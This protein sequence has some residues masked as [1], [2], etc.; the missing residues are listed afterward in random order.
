MNQ[1]LPMVGNIEG[2]MEGRDARCVTRD[3]NLNFVAVI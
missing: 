3:P 2:E 1:A